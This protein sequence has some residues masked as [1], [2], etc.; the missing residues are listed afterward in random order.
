MFNYFIMLCK[1]IKSY[2][3][4]KTLKKTVLKNER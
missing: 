2:D 3:A 4:N 1:K